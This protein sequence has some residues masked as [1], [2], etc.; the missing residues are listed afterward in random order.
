MKSENKAAMIRFLL[1]DGESNKA[2]ARI[3]GCGEAYVRAVRQRM[4]RG[5]Q[6]PAD[7]NWI[8]KNLESERARRRRLSSEH[9]YR[10]RAAILQRQSDRYHSDPSF[11]ARKAEYNRQY[12]AA[13][14][15]E[16]VA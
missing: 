6:S 16:A 2:I 15:R 3:I 12:Y 8:S 5:G 7:R 14:R 4:V 9:Y 11:R 1:K 13:R 10:N